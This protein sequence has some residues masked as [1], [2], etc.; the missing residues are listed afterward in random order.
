MFIGFFQE[1]CSTQQII[2]SKIKQQIHVKYTYLYVVIIYNMVIMSTW[3][4]DMPIQVNDVYAYILVCYY[5]TMRTMFN[6]FP[7]YM[8][9]YVLI[10]IIRPHRINF[11]TAYT[12]TKYDSLSLNPCPLLLR[13][14]PC[15]RLTFN[16]NGSLL[17]CLNHKEN[18][19]LGECLIHLY[20][21]M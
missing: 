9:P 12:R 4:G 21:T 7:R 6:R 15:K 17:T 10:N 13:W 1:M 2:Q 18:E 8:A 16:L 19:C 11:Y 3:C 5:R 20:H 14:L